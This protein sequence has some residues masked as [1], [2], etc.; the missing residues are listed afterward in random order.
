[1][2]NIEDSQ[3]A[4]VTSVFPN[5]VKIEVEDL[6]TFKKN[7]D[8]ALGDLKIGSYLEISDNDGCKLIAVIESYQIE[9][10]ERFLKD[11]DGKL[12]DD[13]EIYNAY[14][15]E[16][17]PL[18]TISGGE[19]TRG[20]DALTIP[21]TEVRPASHSDIKIIFENGF[22]PEEKFLFASL[23]Q[24]KNIKVPVNGNKFF[25]KH[26]TIVG[27]SGSGKSHCT[28]KVL[29]KAV[30]A[31]NGSYQGLNNSHIIIFDIHNEYKTAFPTG[32][33]LG[34]SN[35]VLPYWLLNS[36]E[37]ED[38]FLESGDFNNYNQASVLRDLIIENKKENNPS[39]TSDVYFDSPL[40]FNLAEILY[41][42]KNLSNETKNT[43]SNR[44]MLVDDSIYTL[45]DGRTEVSSGIEL[46]KTERTK[47]YF[48]KIHEF[49][50][51][52]QSSIKKGDYAD[53]SLDKFISRVENKLHDKRLDF[54]LGEKSKGISFEETIKQFI[55]YNKRINNESVEVDQANVT[56]IDLSGI[57]FE[58]LSITVSLISR[59]LFDYSYFY[60]KYLD[61]NSDLDTPLLLVYEEAHKYV[62]KDNSARFRSSRNSI[63]R[64]AKEGRKYGIT[65]GIISQRPSEISETIFS[66]CN[67]FIVMRLTN[68]NDQN[69]VKKLLPDALGNL[70]ESLPSLQCGQGLL[71]GESIIM[72]SLVNIEACSVNMQPS[73]NDVN[74]LEIWKEEW[75]DVNFSNITKEWNS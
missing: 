58:I 72:P 8:D 10:K 27:S 3:L 66:Q 52:K 1:M 62:P 74:Y 14:V 21:P 26:F 59:I 44:Y 37:L 12:T 28:A 73:S 29:Q 49:H 30:E 34:V 75:K 4:H 68:P 57:P 17:S 46:T 33:Y 38:L 16:A 25:N 15:L 2:T 61:D 60:K 51:T 45:T 47:K 63:E 35:L 11:G 41:A 70:I 19:F 36:E 7:I 20:G 50:P 43:K 64:I 9:L 42:L 55:G 13:K 65:L 23:S 48:Q 53:G 54:L 71:L 32:N 6:T 69:Y 31:K 18:G 40:P 5:K 22:K 67:N 56:V 24:D 39:F